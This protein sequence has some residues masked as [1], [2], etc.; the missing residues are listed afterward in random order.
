MGSKW[1]R[2]YF[3]IWYIVGVVM[4]YNIMVAFIID[5]L[6]TKWD[7]DRNKMIKRD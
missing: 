3:I 4:A 7:E 5:Y 2:I 6:V 1:Y